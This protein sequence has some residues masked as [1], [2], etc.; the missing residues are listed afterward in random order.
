MPVSDFSGLISSAC[1]L[2]SAAAIAPIV[3]LQRCMARLQCEEFEANR[4]RF[5]ALSSDAM[6]E[7]FLGILRHVLR[8][9]VVVIIIRRGAPPSQLTFPPQ[10]SFAVVCCHLTAEA[11]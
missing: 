9:V 7:R 1:A 4:A 5:R 11:A 2:A 10:L 8:L 3:S 6:A